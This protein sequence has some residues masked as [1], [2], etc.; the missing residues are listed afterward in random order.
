MTSISRGANES[1]DT[2]PYSNGK[3]ARY[4]VGKSLIREI[5]LPVSAA[6]GR[7]EHVEWRWVDLAT[8]RGARFTPAA[9]RAR[10]G[11][12]QR[13]RSS[14][15][16]VS[17]DAS[18]RA[19]RRGRIRASAQPVSFLAARKCLNIR[20]NFVQRALPGFDRTPRDVRRDYQVGY[21]QIE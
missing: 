1:I 18:F 8:A 17:P 2:G 14:S 21:F 5:G 16:A 6:T 19:L 20:E 12:K 9:A 11:R 10:L 13:A 15:P 3:I 7:P 4:F